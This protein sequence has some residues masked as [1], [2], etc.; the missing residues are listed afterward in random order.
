MILGQIERL[1][2]LL[3]R[4]LS[5]T[6]RDPPRRQTTSVRAILEGCADE[7]AELALAKGITIETSL[8]IE[9]AA[10]DSEQ[11]RR[12]LDNLL[13]NAIEA[14]PLHSKIFISA[15]V[16]DDNLKLTVH[17]EGAGPP[18]S[19]PRSP[20]RTV[21]DRPSGRDGPRTLAGARD[22]E[23]ARRHRDFH[24]RVARHVI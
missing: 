6:E 4:L 20:V 19:I 13:L 2:R 16:K 18:A 14:A 9:T 1:D 3:K 10:F 22:R 5:L 24:D 12:A 21:R 11:I 7:H 8:E 23:R 15:Q 17:D